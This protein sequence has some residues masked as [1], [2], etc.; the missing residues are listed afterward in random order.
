MNIINLIIFLWVYSLFTNMYI[1]RYLWHKIERKKWN[2]AFCITST[3]CMCRPYIVYSLSTP[4]RPWTSTPSH[5][6]CLAPLSALACSTRNISLPVL[7][8]PLTPPTDNRLLSFVAIGVNT[9]TTLA[10]ILAPTRQVDRYQGLALTNNWTR[11]VGALADFF[12]ISCLSITNNLISIKHAQSS[13]SRSSPT[14]TRL[15]HQP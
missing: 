2:S 7:P 13:H 14:Y 5:G 6:P 11:N 9:K 10:E 15:K 8:S 1:K 4:E 12:D 3:L